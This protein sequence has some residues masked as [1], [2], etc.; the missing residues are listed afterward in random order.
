MLSIM[1][2]EDNGFFRRTIRDSLCARF[3]TIGIAEAEDG[4]ETVQKLAA[5]R[6]DLIFMG[7]ALR[8]KNGIQVT[9]EIKNMFP[10]SIVVIVTGY[11]KEF[12][13]SAAVQ[14]GASGFICKSPTNVVTDLFHVVKCFQGAKEKGRPKPG[15]FLI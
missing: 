5:N 15:C 14:A 8:G 3:Q 2:V 10:K 1:L 13:E 7:I 12:S 4:K 9:K 11:E 6:A